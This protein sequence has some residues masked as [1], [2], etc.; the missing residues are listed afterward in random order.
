MFIAADEICPPVV[1]QLFLD[2]EGFFDLNKWRNAVKTAS[3][4]NPGSR[5]ILKGHLAGSRWVDSGV[6][7]EVIEIDSGRWDCTGPDGAPFLEKRLIPR[8]GPTCEVLLLHGNPLRVCFRTHH[9]VM[10]GRGTLL[11]AED[12]FRVLR[13]EEPSGSHSAITDTEL[14]RSVQAEYRTPFPRNCI[15][16]TGQPGKPARGVTW[17]RIT[18]PGSFKNILGQVM[19][20]SAREAWKHQ[21]GPVRFSI[22]V[23][24][25]PLDKNVKSTG[26]LAIAIYVEVKQDSTPESISYDIKKQL[27]GKRECMIDRFDPLIC[28]LPIG[29]LKRAG[30][31]RIKTGTMNMKYG[32]SG[33]LSNMGFIPVNVFKKVF[34]GGGFNSNIL[35]GIPPS[36]ENVPFFLGLTSR[37]NT[38]EIILTLPKV[39]ADNNRLDNILKSIKN[40][41]IQS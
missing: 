14:A 25:R 28:H 6:T 10:D 27:E 29:L 3:A 31:Y 13:G 40:K 8:E 11:W 39:L 19:V 33:I 21:Q 30:N 20:I 15:A 24:L 22:P 9:S 5:L 23:D 2:G 26:N 12:I 36:F 38:L 17:K 34:S 4:A 18:I 7:P 32:T 41:L 16:P 37:E 1:N 35:W